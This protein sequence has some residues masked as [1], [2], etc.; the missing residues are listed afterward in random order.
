MPSTLDMKDVSTRDGRSATGPPGDDL[1]AR[2]FA[3]FSWYLLCLAVVAQ[4]ASH[5]WWLVRSGNPHWVMPHLV[6]WW[7]DGVILVVLYGLSL[8]LAG[9]RPGFLRPS[10]VHRALLG[11]WAAVF[12]TLLLYPRFLPDLLHFP[13]NVFLVDIGAVHTFF[14]YF[15]DWG[16]LAVSLATTAICVAT[17]HGLASR[18]CAPLAATPA[19]GMD[20]STSVCTSESPLRWRRWSVAAGVAA[21]A[22]TGFT[23]ARPSPHPL[24]FSLQDS[25]IG[26]LGGPRAVPRLVSPQHDA[27]AQPEKAMPPDVFVDFPAAASVAHI[28]V[29]VMETV[30]QERFERELLTNPRSFIGSKQ[31]EFRL[32]SAYHT[33]NLDSY[34]SL[35]AMLTGV[36]VPYQAYA[37]PDRFSGINGAPNLVDTLRQTGRETLFI[38]TAN[39]QPFVPLRRAWHRVVTR[40]DLPANPSLVAVESPPIEAAVEDRAARPAII[41]FVRRHPRTFVMQECVFGHAQVW[42]DRTRTSQLEY[43]DRYIGELIHDLQAGNDWNRT[44]LVLVAD[45]GSREDAANPEHYRVPLVL[46]GPGVK[47]G[48][49]T[50]FLSHLVLPLILRE[51]L[52]GTNGAPATAG[53][54]PVLTV[55]HSGS[56]IYGE[57]RADGTSQFIE[58]VRGRV[59]GG[60][61]NVDPIAL[62]RR[63]QAN[64]A[65]FA[66]RFP[67]PRRG[68]S[69]VSR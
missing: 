35:L 15:L 16:G 33:P 12:G 13:V 30:E 28:I 61:G 51:V 14:R 19:E 3:A 50:R 7:H 9:L 10:V 49:D 26:W 4:F 41:E 56:W 31:A 40:S 11:V 53:G 69:A 54:S 8:G 1:D 5:C 64:L 6:A 25:V 32:F 62:H 39:H 46:W 45:H 68:G 59:L 29:V 60:R 36:S 43:M 22:V 21:L 52:T 44:L 57:I 34:T 24:L 48:R 42:L 20:L 47:P 55:G 67:D 27:T 65:A 38:C 37:D 58:N 66:R 63:F 17:A 18:R 23:L 2:Y